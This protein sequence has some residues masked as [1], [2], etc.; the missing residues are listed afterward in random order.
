[1][2]ESTSVV[3]VSDSPCVSTTTSTATFSN[4]FLTLFPHSATPDHDDDDEIASKHPS[5]LS[6]PSSSSLSATPT[7]T[8][9]PTTITSFTSD[10]EAIRISII[11]NP[12]P[13]PPLNV[14]DFH[15]QH[16]SN[17]TSTTGSTNTTADHEAPS[18][19]FSSSSSRSSASSSYH[20]RYDIQHL[21]R[22]LEQFF[23]FSFLL[24]LVF[25]RQHFRGF[26]IVLWIAA[27]LFKSN[28]VLRKQ[29]AL[30]GDRNDLVLIAMILMFLVH[31]VSVYWWYRHTDLFCPLLLLPPPQVPPFWHAVFIITVNDVMV[32][33]LAMACKCALLMRCK[34]SRGHNHRKQGQL[35]TLIEYLSLLYRALLPTPVWFRF[36][37]NKEYGSFFSSLVTGLYLTVKLTSILRKVQL[38]IAASRALSR[39]EMHYGS[40]ATSEQVNAAGDLCAICQEK[41][42][43]PVLLCCKH[44]F[45]EDCVSEW[46]EHERTCP[47]CRALVKPA[48]IQSYS[49]GSTN[50]LFQLF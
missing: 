35:L 8:P 20:Q 34:S 3:T 17:H 1:M 31:V 40:Y 48:D 29:T 33:Q 12:I 47:L 21:G 11:E 39:K 38:F 25:I 15:Y 10:S 16:L 19:P 14:A 24:L 27:V 43:A 4:H 23:P 9:T 7:P 26:C 41:M 32:R 2:T 37:L 13:I 5:L 22:C 6:S 42:H 50:L 36:F 45:C 28:D 46:F 18:S 30:R 44:V 49:D